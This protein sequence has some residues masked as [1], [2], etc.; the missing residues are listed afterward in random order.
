[1]GATV[2][3]KS[4]RA[5]PIP[6]RAPP[7]RSFMAQARESDVIERFDKLAGSVLLT[8]F[9][10]SQVVGH[11]VNTLKYWRLHSI[12]TEVR[13]PLRMPSASVRYSV[14]SVRAW[15]ANLPE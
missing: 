15:L 6:T 4:A 10:V 5:A 8:E 14:A 13:K 1:M 12:S 3:S 11:P 2:R 7:K 9:E